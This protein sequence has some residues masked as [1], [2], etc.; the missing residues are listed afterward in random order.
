MN[1]K[2]EHQYF[3]FGG[4]RARY[5]TEE[6]LNERLTGHLSQKA[7]DQFKQHQEDKLNHPAFCKP[8]TTIK[9]VVERPVM[10]KKPIEQFF[11]V[12]EAMVIE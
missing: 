11:D 2:N 9:S 5:E 4:F 3:Y 12:S 1:G 6:E 8:G 10:F 7:K